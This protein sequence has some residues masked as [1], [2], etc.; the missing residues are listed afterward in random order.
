MRVNIAIKI[1]LDIRG[2]K[3]ASHG[4]L[5]GCVDKGLQQFFHFFYAFQFRKMYFQDK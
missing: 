2:G 3:E 4:G 1:F 5:I